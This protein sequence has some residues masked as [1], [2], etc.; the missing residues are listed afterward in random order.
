[1]HPC[2]IFSRWLMQGRNV[3]LP[4]PLGPMSTTVS[5]GHTVRSMPRSTSVRPNRLCTSWANTIGAASGV[6]SSLF[7]FARIVKLRASGADHIAAQASPESYA[8]LT[9]GALGKLALHPALAQGSQRGHRQVV[10]RND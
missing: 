4:D 8:L 10:A 1:M 5:L 7:I 9:R 3:V 2:S 6:A